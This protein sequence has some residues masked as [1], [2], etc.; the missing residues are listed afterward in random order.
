MDVL[1][2]Q[3]RPH[4]FVGRRADGRQKTITSTSRPSKAVP[5][6]TT[7]IASQPD[8]PPPERRLLN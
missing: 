1:L 4:P 5:A 6:T 8:H 3:Q 2:D 7:N